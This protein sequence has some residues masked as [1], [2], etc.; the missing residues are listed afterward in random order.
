VE[1][2]KARFRCFTRDEK[3]E[4]A[5]AAFR[6]RFGQD[7]LVTFKDDMLRVG[8]VPGDEHLLTDA[9]RVTY[10]EKGVEANG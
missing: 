4:N 6:L 10:L 9:E 3:A 8:P 5:I 1:D 2:R 7:P